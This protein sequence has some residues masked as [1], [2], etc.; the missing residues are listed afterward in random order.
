MLGAMS[1]PID[2]VVG[3]LLSLAIVLTSA[4]IAGHVATRIGQPAVLGEL[5]VGLLLGNVTLVGYSG[6]DYLKDRSLPRHVVATG[7]DHPA[8]SGE[9]GLIFA[10][11]GLTLFVA[12]K[13]VVDTSVSSTVVMMVMATTAVAPPAIKWSFSR[14]GRAAGE[15]DRARTAAAPRV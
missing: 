4:K 13:P 3:L 1:A 7:R 2:P 10:N 6:L 15:A 5:T 12:G 8:V 9:V 11:I 14:R